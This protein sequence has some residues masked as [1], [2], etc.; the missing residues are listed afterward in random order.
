MQ[1]AVQ[2]VTAAGR[3]RAIDVERAHRPRTQHVGCADSGCGQ[4]GCGPAG[5]R[6]RRLRRSLL[7]A[8]PP[9]GIAP[10][11]S[12]A[13]AIRK[14]QTDEIIV[15]PVTAADVRSLGRPVG[16][17]AG[18]KRPAAIQRTTRGLGAPAVKTPPA[19]RR[20]PTFTAPR[21]PIRITAP[22]RPRRPVTQVRSP[23]SV[24]PV[25]TPVERQARDAGELVDARSEAPASGRAGQA[26]GRLRRAGRL[27]GST[28]P[29]STGQTQTRVQGQPG[30]PA[31]IIGT[32]GG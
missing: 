1:P 9:T 23:A 7:G 10:F 17:T 16:R 5:L 19:V 31:P 15:G 14:V 25:R 18:A 6:P 4:P 3:V 22:V 28:T 24:A 27:S 32:S 21:Q 20:T 30:G 12:L 11:A 26:A 13:G 29:A 2:R 8:P